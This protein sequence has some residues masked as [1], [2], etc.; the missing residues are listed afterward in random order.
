MKKKRYY[1]FGYRMEQGQILP[2]PEEAGLLQYLF[3]AYLEGA[4]LRQTAELAMR[5][6]IPYHE[7]GN[8]WSKCTVSRI[9]ADE[10]YWDCK[11]PPI[12]DTETGRAVLQ[13]RKEQASAPSPLPFLRKKVL[14]GKCGSLLHRDSRS[15]P[16]IVWKCETCS[17]RFG[18]QTDQELLREITKKLHELCRTPERSLSSEAHKEQ[19][20]LYIVRLTNQ[21][22]HLLD[23]R[24]VDPDEL[25]PLVLECAQE[26]YSQSR[27]A[28]NPQEERIC[29]LLAQHA[30]DE[31]L[32]PN[33]FHQVIKGVVLRERCTIR[34]RLWNGIEF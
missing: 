16:H 5:S 15:S 13:R 4:S 32:D 6:G 7:N 17:E 22:H 29:A 2:V 19:I 3:S 23:S 1:P 26:K 9:L 28:S 21:I 18:P 8:G 27:L 14:C 10:R 11:L 12:I 24:D 30:D 31:E 25:L 33:F 34:L 20:S